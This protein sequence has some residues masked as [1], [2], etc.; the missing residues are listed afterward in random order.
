MTARLELVWPGKDKFLLVPKDEAGE[1]VWVSSSQP[2]KVHDA[3][4]AA[5]SRMAPSGGL[6]KMQE[7]HQ[8]GGFPSSMGELVTEGGQRA[9]EGG[10][11]GWFTVV[12]II[13]NGTY[14]KEVDVGLFRNS[15][16]GELVRISGTSAS[17]PWTHHAF[18]PHP[19]TEVG[20]T[21]TSAA[22]RSVADA[23][24]A[25]AAL[26][27]T[28]ARLPNPRLF[29]HSS[30]RLEAQSTAALEG[31]YEP[32]A[33]VLTEDP[34]DGHDPS[35]REVLNYLTVAETAFEW[36][37][38]GRA[39]SLNTIGELYRMLMKGTAGERDYSGVRPIQAV[40]GRR[41]DARPDEH[42]I[43]A[44]RYVPPP[45]GDDLAA[46]FSDLL[47]W[48]YADH[49]ASIDPVVAAAMG[50]YTFEALHPFHDGN[51]RIGRLFIV[52]QL[53]RHGIL[54]EPSITVS[55]WFEAR[56]QRYYDALLG[57]SATGDWST[58]VSMF[59]EGL[60]RSAITAQDRM[61]ALA[62]AQADLK[63][64][65]QRSRSTTSS[66]PP[67]SPRITSL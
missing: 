35:M 26:D 15:P 39:W 8:C 41:E 23:R 59:A 47:D 65:L 28:A 53:N 57:V 31:T 67:T 62:Q 4:Y 45:P 6:R 49:R 38:Q 1:P 22:Y 25:L 33:R 60:A 7:T 52:L 5:Q 42:P 19:L 24:A 13:R 61:L 14:R 55:P 36:A 32:L 21:L 17:G 3:P 63:D 44:A 34:Y 16:S 50:H 9:G 10:E 2:R 40:V 29:R 56:R 11:T 30:L 12:A 58:W 64:R 20:P 51:G 18:L 27:A 54:T 66:T 48:M 43:H 37:A 46:R